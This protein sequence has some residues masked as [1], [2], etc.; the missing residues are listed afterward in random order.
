MCLSLEH[1]LFTWASLD[2]LIYLF[3]FWIFL[4][5]NIESLYE[6]LLSECQYRKNRRSEL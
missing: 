4:E 5:F 6:V 2:Y 3:L 1:T